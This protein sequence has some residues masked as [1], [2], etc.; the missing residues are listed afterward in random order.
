LAITLSECPSHVLT[1]FKAVVSKPSAQRGAVRFS[2][3]HQ[4]IKLVAG[5]CRDRSKKGW[6]YNMGNNSYSISI[7]PKPK[8]KRMYIK[9]PSEVGYLIF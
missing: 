5:V 3:P 4:A 9:V 2:P 1:D 8:K 7:L 6:R